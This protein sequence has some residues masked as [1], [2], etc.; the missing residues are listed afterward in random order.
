MPQRNLLKLIEKSFGSFDRLKVLISATA[1]NV[2][3]KGWGIAACQPY[4]D[5]LVVL[6]C[7]NHEKLTQWG[8][9]PILVIDV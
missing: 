7:E 1:K 2:D 8:A 6:Q 3:A 4:S 9:I 5:S